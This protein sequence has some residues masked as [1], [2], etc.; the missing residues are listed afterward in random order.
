[1]TLKSTLI[2][3]PFRRKTCTERP[4]CA[5]FDPP[6]PAQNATFCAETTPA[7]PP[8]LPFPFSRTRF[9]L[10]ISAPKYRR[11]HFVKISELPVN[12]HPTIQ[13]HY[14][15]RPI[16]SSQPH[17]PSR[18]DDG[19]AYGKPI[20]C[21]KQTHRESRPKSAGGLRPLKTRSVAPT[22]RPAR[23]FEATRRSL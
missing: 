1:M 22:R 19:F 6:K 9:S 4:F 8:F 7:N 11:P 2:N 5:A 18:P 12:E 14:F 15:S 3:S 16:T 13:K 23:N 17:S 21:R 10:K 20:L